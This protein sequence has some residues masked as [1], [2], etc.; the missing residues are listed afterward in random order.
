MPRLPKENPA[1]PGLSF[2]EGAGEEL[3]CGLKGRL[4]EACSVREPNIII[5]LG[6]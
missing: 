6:Q 3:P 2:A 4:G 5:V 1:T